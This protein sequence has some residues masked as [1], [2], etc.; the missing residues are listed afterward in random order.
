MLVTGAHKAD[1]CCTIARTDP[2]SSGRHGLSMF[3][4]PMAT[5][6]IEITRHATANR[7]TL[8]TL[9]FA[10]VAVDRGAVLGQLDQ[11]WKQ[12]TGALLGERSG[13]AWMGWATRNLEALLAHC[14]GTQRSRSCAASSPVS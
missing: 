1:W 8:S 12:L 11:G 5:P 13:S 3:L 2:A 7:W 6:G 10:D 14:T 4:F 9:R